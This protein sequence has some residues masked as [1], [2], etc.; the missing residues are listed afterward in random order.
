MA[1]VDWDR[2]VFVLIAP[3]ALV[4]R[5]AH[6]VLD[7]MGAAGFHPVGWRVIWH[8]PADLDAFNE[9]N[10]KQAWQGYLY[11]LVD[12][13]FSIGPTIAL[14]AHD[15]RPEDGLTTHQRMRRLKGASEPA[16]AGPDTIRGALASVNVMLALMHSS[17]TAAD[18]RHESDVFTGETGYLCGD[19]AELYHLVRLL[20]GAQPEETRG[21]AQVLGGLRARVLAAVWDELG[22]D[23]RRTALGLDPAQLGQPGAGKPLADLLPAGHPLAA[24]LRADFTPENPGPL[25]DRVRR[26]LP[27]YGL[28]LDPW[29]DLVL[30][31]SRRF[32]PRP[33]ALSTRAA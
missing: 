17:D 28:A 18:A 2:T 16:D 3:D 13:L 24:T 12:Q 7:M 4:R 25:L 27:A 33:W 10:I 20:Q 21:H 32:A 26:L 30:T 14:I 11:R 1:E 29:E 19:P 6:R 15:G 5:V 9:R 8:R 22:A 23:A 31:T